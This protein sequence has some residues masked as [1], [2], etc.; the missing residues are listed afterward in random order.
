MLPRAFA[1][2]GVFAA[3]ITVVL[4]PLA[5]VDAAPIK[6]TPTK[7]APVA[8]P[9]KLSADPGNP[10]QPTLL[11]SWHFADQ[12][13]I[14]SAKVTYRPYGQYTWPF[15]VPDQHWGAQGVVPNGTGLDKADFFMPP[16][17]GYF[18][19]YSFPYWI[20]LTTTRAAKISIVWRNP[21]TPNWLNDLGFVAAGTTHAD[22]F[23]NCHGDCRVFTKTT[24]GAGDVWLGGPSVDGG[25]T[26]MYY[27]L[28]Q[29]ANGSNPQP[30]SQLH[31]PAAQPNQ[32][33]PAWVH[34]QYMTTDSFSGKTFPTWHP[35]IDPVYFCTFG[36]DHGSDP[37]LFPVPG[38]GTLHPLYGY[39]D[40]KMG[41]SEAHEGF[42]D[43]VV[44]TGN[45]IWFFEQHFGSNSI[46]GVCN[47]MHELVIWEA[48]VGSSTPNMAL[49]I[50]GDFGV[51]ED[52]NTLARLQAQAC[53]NQGV[54][55]TGNGARTF[56]TAGPNLT[57]YEP[58]RTNDLSSTVIGLQGALTFNTLDPTVILSAIIGGSMN[59]D[60]LSGTHRYFQTNRNFAFHTPNIP[61]SAQ[62][63][64]RYGN[65]HD[66]VVW[67]NAAGTAW[68]TPGASGA[69]A[70]Y[71]K[72]GWAGVV[73]DYPS[74]E[75]DNFFVDGVNCFG[76]V[77]TYVNIH[78]GGGRDCNLMG[79]I[80]KN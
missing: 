2:L 44:Q 3:A 5:S 69:T 58:W 11:A 65:A 30:P 45:Q 17:E 19:T 7:T 42:K 70:Q 32:P 80:T 46:A 67:T 4:M 56:P 78:A 57:F 34:D 74:V 63:D 9:K 38:W 47:S 61:Q 18:R 54:G 75:G 77:Y 43:Y 29:E 20:D 79:A 6:G 66:G 21:G 39:A 53:P 50:V 40:D 13:N 59:P 36:H 24:S 31:S 8:A 71:I 62:G 14:D 64:T 55:Y 37:S 76:E 60:G 41:M 28:L 25:E 22:Q 51:A 73:W 52:N 10:N 1:C 12:V 33:C 68:S 23:W 49:S 72:P 35:Q 27:V 15:A 26:D 48:D 16:S